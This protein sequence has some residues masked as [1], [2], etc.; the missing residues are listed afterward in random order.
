MTLTSAP[1]KWISKAISNSPVL[2]TVWKTC[3]KNWWSAL[4]WGLFTLAGSLLP[5]WATLFIRGVH[6]QPYRLE[7][8]VLRGDL[9]LYAAAFLAPAIYQIV[10]RMKNNTS[11]LGLGAVI[12][13]VMAILASA[14]VYMVVNPELISQ[15]P[16]EQ[17]HETALLDFVSYS[18]L[19]ASVVFSVFVFLN[20]QQLEFTDLKGAEKIDQAV[21]TAVFEE[22]NPTAAHVS[23]LTQPPDAAEQETEETLSQ[24][25]TEDADV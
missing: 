21:L 5:L 11:F 15:T 23:I 14:I 1:N 16:A 2:V 10:F 19:L 8:F 25:F 7:D 6:G 24:K 20:E 3:R 12:I 22:K 17:I 4:L 9:V 13:A 18:L